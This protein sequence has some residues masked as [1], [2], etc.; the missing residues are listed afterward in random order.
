M[1]KFHLL[2]PMHLF[3]GYL[4]NR[5]CTL[6]LSTYYSLIFFQ[7]IPKVH[8]SI[9]AQMNDKQED[10]SEYSFRKYAATYFSSTANYQFSKKP[11]KESLHYLPT[12]DDT[13]AAQAIWITILRFMGD[14]PEPKYDDNQKANE[15]IMNIV[16]ETLSRSFT[17]RKEYRVRRKSLKFT[18]KC[19][20]S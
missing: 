3:I 14:Y 2:L 8:I 6:L 11:L 9:G 20:D 1:I 16:S 18:Q 19:F 4:S 10:L 12:P 15:P 5:Y 7:I 17:N 13:I